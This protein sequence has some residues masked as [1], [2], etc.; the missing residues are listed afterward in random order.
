MNDF[1]SVHNVVFGNR[2]SIVIESESG[3]LRA[4]IEPRDKEKP[5]DI[6]RVVCA[7]DDKHRPPLCFDEFGRFGIAKDEVKEQTKDLLAHYYDALSFNDPHGIYEYEENLFDFNDGPEW[8]SVG[9]LID[10]LPNFEECYQ[11]WKSKHNPSGKEPTLKEKRL[12]NPRKNNTVW[13]IA[14]GLIRAVISEHLSSKDK[15]T[16]AI[17]EELL[18]EAKSTETMR[19][20]NKLQS[21]APDHITM[22]EKTFRT[23][24]K[25]IFTINK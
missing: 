3:P 9:W 7:I 13:R 4:H 19:L 16:K 12:E 10:E 25:Q 20:F 1:V 18:S 14:E 5:I 8:H 17:I 11:Q 22:D 24:L 6:R 23:K 2:P 21:L 15:S